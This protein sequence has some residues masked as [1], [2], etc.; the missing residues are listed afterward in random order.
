MSIASRNHPDIAG[1]YA[2]E[3]TTGGE[4]CVSIYPG[5]NNIVENSISDGNQ[6]LFDIQATSTS[7]GNALLGS[8]SRNGYYGVVIKARGSTDPLMPHGTIVK[9]VVVINASS[10][11]LYSRSA[12]GTRCDNCSFWDGSMNGLLADK[13]TSYPGDGNYSIFSDNSLAVNNASTGF[14]VTN[15]VATWT[16]DTPNAYSNSTNYSPSSSPNLINNSEN[17]PQVGSCKVYIPDGSSMKNAG[18]NGKDIGA[19]VLYRY[20]NGV[21]TGQRLWDPGTGKFPCGAIVG[22]VNDI[23]GTSCFDV[24]TRLNVNTTGCPFPAVY[25]QGGPDFGPPAAPGNLRILP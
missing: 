4:V 20:E 22:G 24:H 6:T 8:I 5:S 10:P 19:N 18:K 11:G 7:D 25:A 16:I 2:S 14:R 3:N 9:N 23:P 21:L 1:G 12:K 13:D 15:D 17:D